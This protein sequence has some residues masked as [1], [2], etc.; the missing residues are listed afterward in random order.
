MFQKNKSEYGT[1]AGDDKRDE[2][3]PHSIKI[4]EYFQ[5]QNQEDFDK[6][7][8]THLIHNGA[9]SSDLTINEDDERFKTLKHLLEDLRP[10]DKKKKKKAHH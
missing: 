6:I 9:M 4:N 3:P 10:N 8:K 2:S 7:I 5:K 1:V